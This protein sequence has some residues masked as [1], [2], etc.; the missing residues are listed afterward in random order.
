M[1]ALAGR[2][3]RRCAMRVALPALVIVACHAGCAVRTPAPP[4]PTTPDSTGNSGVTPIVGPSWRPADVVTPDAS[5]PRGF[6]VLGPDRAPIVLTRHEDEGSAELW[7]PAE[8]LPTSVFSM[9]DDD[10]IASIQ[11]WI[12]VLELSEDDPGRRPEIPPRRAVDGMLALPRHARPR[13]LAIILG[14]LARLNPP[15]QWL[16][17]TFLERGWAV[18]VSSPPVAAPDAVTGGVTTLAPGRSPVEAGRTLAAEVDTSLGCWRDGL[19]AIVT[20]L[21]T[22]Q[23]LPAGPTVIVGASSGAIAAPLVA[24][25]LAATRP[26]SAVVM[27]AGGA[28]PP[29]ILARTTLS[30]QDLRLDRR[31]PR[32]STLDLPRFVAAFDA[33]SRLQGPAAEHAAAER[34]GIGPVLV[35]EAGFDTAIP[36]AARHR[37]RDLHPGAARWWYPLGHVGLF[38][39]LA[40]ETDRVVDW[41]ESVVDTDSSNRPAPAADDPVPWPLE[42]S[43]VPQSQDPGKDLSRCV[44]SSR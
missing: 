5:Q 37:L 1:S 27:V 6:A 41:I 3:G 4:R 14:S 7:T 36:E 39:A 9:I 22:L 21:E 38:L 34:I 2:V 18:L 26:V 12:A 28:S 10:P 23:T 17:S 35:L 43:P 29:R 40:A 8:T 33:D 19:S 44:E 42:G 31:G 24:D 11:A 30:D 20:R 16:T 32:V 25:R 13:G 15:E